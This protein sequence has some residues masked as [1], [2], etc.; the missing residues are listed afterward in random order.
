MA[1]SGLS[2]GNKKVGPPGSGSNASRRYGRGER[3]RAPLAASLPYTDPTGAAPTDDQLHSAKAGYYYE[4]AGSRYAYAAAKGYDV[5][6]IANFSKLTGLHPI[7]ASTDLN[8]GN[9]L[10]DAGWLA[11]AKAN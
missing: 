10:S 2:P 11:W 3:I 5:L 8:N 6:K 9:T 7:K 1:G 4:L